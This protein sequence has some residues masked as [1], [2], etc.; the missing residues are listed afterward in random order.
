MPNVTVFSNN[1]ADD[2]EK[3]R[4]GM[5]AAGNRINEWMK[6]RNSK[7]YTKFFDELFTEIDN[8]EPGTK[9]HSFK[10]TFGAE[11][12]I[13]YSSPNYVL[14]DGRKFDPKP[15]ADGKQGNDTGMGKKPVQMTISIPREQADLL[16]P[17]SYIDIIIKDIAAFL[18]IDLNTI[19]DEKKAALKKYFLAVIFLNRCQ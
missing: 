5:A 18:G 17:D 11:V 6:N 8:E 3:R 15:Q 9:P 4:N 2:D 19:A 12:P 7:N 10:L 16:E 13:T 1:G 14:P